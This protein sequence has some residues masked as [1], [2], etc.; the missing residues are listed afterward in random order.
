MLVKYL[1]LLCRSGLT[2]RGFCSDLLTASSRSQ[3][4]ATIKLVFFS[5]YPRYPP[6][7]S[8]YISSVLEPR[9]TGFAQFCEVNS[10]SL[11]RRQW[12][13]APLPS[14]ELLNRLCHWTDL[15]FKKNRSP[16]TLAVSLDWSVAPRRRFCNR[17]NTFLTFYENNRG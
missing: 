9:T 2:N 15:F 10:V 16:I 5:F 1:A 6:C 14:P 13:P 7:I 4:R 11:S 17:T 12:H 8:L 3:L